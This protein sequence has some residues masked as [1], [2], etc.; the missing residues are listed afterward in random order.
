MSKALKMMPKRK[1]KSV[2]SVQNR[3]Q[4]DFR[5]FYEEF[6]KKRIA[7][8]QK[9][10]KISSNVAWSEIRTKIK[11]SS[12][13]YFEI[14]EGTGYNS[15]NQILR[16]QCLNHYKNLQ[17]DEKMVN[18]VFEIF[19]SYENWKQENNYYDIED[20]VGIFYKKIRRW[21]YPDFNFD[22]IV[23][24]EVQDLS[25]NSIQV[26][27]NLCL[28]NFFICGDN[29][30]NIEKGINF[31]FKD[32]RSFLNGAIANRSEKTVEYGDNYYN[33]SKSLTQISHY[34]LGLNFR[35]SKQ[36]LDLANMV[37]CIL[38]TYFF[39]EIDSFPKERGFFSSP[40]PVVVELGEDINFLVNL[41]ETYLKMEVTVESEELMEE[42]SMDQSAVLLNKK[43]KVGSDFCI[44]VRNEEAKKDVPE[45]L[46]NCIILTLQESKGLEFENVLL[47][48]HFIGNDAEKGWRYIFTRTGLNHRSTTKE[49]EKEMAE[50]MDLFRKSKLELRK[51]TR[52]GEE[53]LWEFSTGASLDQ[54]STQTQLEGLSADLKFLY[55]AITRAKKN[56]II[57][58]YV[59]VKPSNHLRLDFDSLCKKLDVVQFVDQSRLDSMKDVY[60]IDPNWRSLQQSNAREKG[61]CFLK[62]GEYHT[63]ERFFKIS[64]DERLIKY[65]KAS[66]KAKTGGDLLSL[67]FDEEL[68]KKYPSTVELQR[69]AEKIFIEAAELFLDLEKYNEAGKCYFSAERYTDAVD[70]FVRIENKIF[71]AHSLFMQQKYEQALPIYYQLEQ[72]DL[73]QACLYN[74]SEGGKD[75][76]KFASLLSS[77]SDEGKEVSKLD[78]ATFVNYVKNVFDE[79]MKEIEEEDQKDLEPLS[80]EEGRQISNIASEYEMS[81]NV[82]T[83]E[84][85]SEKSD[86]FVV[87]S[88]PKSEFND[89][90]VEVKSIVSEM[91]SL[92]GSF[93]RVLSIHSSASSRDF[94]ISSKI[95]RKLE[96]HRDRI[97]SILSTMT[98]SEVLFSSSDPKIEYLIYDLS[99]VYKFEDIG[100]QIMKDMGEKNKKVLDRIIVNKMLNLDLNV[101]FTRRV[102]LISISSKPEPAGIQDHLSEIATLNIFDIISGLKFSG[103]DEEI[104]TVDDV[105]RYQFF[106]IAIM[107]LAEFFYPLAHNP[108]V[109]NQLKL[110]L[111][112]SRAN[113]IA[114]REEFLSE[115][116]DEGD[117]SLRNEPFESIVDYL[118]VQLVETNIDEEIVRP[119]DQS[120]RKVELVLDLVRELFLKF[121]DSN[122]K[123]NDQT[124][125]CM[126]EVMQKLEV[127]R[128]IRFLRVV[129]KKRFLIGGKNR[130]DVESAVFKKISVRNG[131]EL[132]LAKSRFEECLLVGK[133]SWILKLAASCFDLKNS[134]KFEKDLF[135]YAIN[136]DEDLFLVET[137]TFN[138]FAFSL[139]LQQLLS[140]FKV[141]SYRDLMLLEIRSRLSS[142]EKSIV[143]LQKI[144]PKKYEEI[145]FNFDFEQS[146]LERV[147]DYFFTKTS[148][149]ISRGKK[150]PSFPTNFFAVYQN[151]TILNRNKDS[152]RVVSGLIR[153]QCTKTENSRVFFL[154]EEIDELL[155]KGEVA[156]AYFKHIDLLEYCE[157]SGVEISKNSA[158]WLALREI[159][160]LV[161][162]YGITPAETQ[163]EEKFYN[164]PDF[165]LL[166]ACFRRELETMDWVLNVGG[167][168]YIDEKRVTAEDTDRIEHGIKDKF[169]N[170]ID[171]LSPLVHSL[172]P[173]LEEYINGLTSTN[174]EGI[175][176]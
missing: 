108:E 143:K 50:E 1:G 99:I 57:Y 59:A 136:R 174:S 20:F 19:E 106:N 51:L 144:Y 141:Q 60:Q 130:K 123:P 66:E 118:N 4:I 102:D 23:I 55:V 167:T 172:Y 146:S 156:R 124:I 109:K 18:L 98:G 17:P 39:N 61:Y 38:E 176:C 107:G 5:T 93:E 134:I 69:E 89:E 73:V 58:D 170:A 24:D 94:E 82:P 85:I 29:A 158:S 120:I 148:T 2:A 173:E 48:N 159:M 95:L 56:M 110:L 65:C 128:L 135:G 40:K 161:L 54:I 145:L 43:I 86:S 92:G 9:L 52:D 70:C 137:T 8:N 46:Q 119:T 7:R 27:T 163:K 33:Q 78:D 53:K 35:S 160:I 15:N 162:C 150:D 151:Y 168:L 41:L 16:S 166:P 169:L 22:L 152:S 125:N 149:M 14:S 96:A 74:L 90:F 30:Q 67:D 36:I 63:A 80:L 91:N 121:V 164:Y 12:F 34:H 139:C 154:L 87:V 31:K 3:R 44:I 26:L 64:N 21:P 105:I 84:N 45:A 81:E 32:L 142:S 76:S 126:N 11:G 88:D 68:K 153:N 104:R 132:S 37:V 75:M 97:S 83:E 138:Q 175:S 71:Q 103:T 112:K 6:Y 47:F 101:A 171:Q 28:N 117:T 10:S 77:L 127:W 100:L 147:E 133:E 111:G 49:E 131:A 114:S 157:D 13:K 113:K 140:R 116:A 165:I 79:L 155:K 122:N 42:S 25:F 115:P 62:Q 129:F 72:D